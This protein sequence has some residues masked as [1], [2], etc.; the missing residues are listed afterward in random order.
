MGELEAL[1]KVKAQAEKIGWFKKQ[2]QMFETAKKR[3][4]DE[5]AAVKK[6]SEQWKERALKSE[7]GEGRLQSQTADID[8]YQSEMNELRFQNRTLIS[9]VIEVRAEQEAAEAE[10]RTLLAEVAELHSTF[11]KVAGENARLAGHDNKKQKIHYTT[12]MREDNQFL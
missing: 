7:V 9:T 3:A 6:E 4:E 12:K 11:D 8:V 10:N 1:D 5:L 2:A